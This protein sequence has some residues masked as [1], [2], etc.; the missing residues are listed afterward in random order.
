MFRVFSVDLIEN[1]N[2]ITIF[3]VKKSLFNLVPSRFKL[4]IFKLHELIS[5]LFFI[6]H[7]Q[8]FSL[9]SLN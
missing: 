7:I 4:L 9:C 8:C 5:N 6:F 3:F 2:L 1:I